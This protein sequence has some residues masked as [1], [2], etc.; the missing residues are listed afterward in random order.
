MELNAAIH[1][2]ATLVK[3]DDSKSKLGPIVNAM[4]HIPEKENASIALLKVSWPIFLEV[5]S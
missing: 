5:S 4:T 1:E 2:A 3:N